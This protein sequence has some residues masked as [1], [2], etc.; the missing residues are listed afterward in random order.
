MSWFYANYSF[1]TMCVAIVS[2]AVAAVC[3]EGRGGKTWCYFSV[4]FLK[5]GVL[6]FRI[7]IL[8][9]T[10]IVVHGNDNTFC[11]SL[12]KDIVLRFL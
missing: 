8:D 12:V 11:R 4:V 7:K 1:K 5:H 9:R 2:L 6:I 10:F 3:S